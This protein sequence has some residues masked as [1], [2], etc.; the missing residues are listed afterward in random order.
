MV[1]LDNG[2]KITGHN[3]IIDCEKGFYNNLYT[4][5]KNTWLTTDASEYFTN[6][7]EFPCLS[8][9]NKDVL[10]TELTAEEIANA[11]EVL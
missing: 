11:V 10:D 2:E 9:E 6:V 4:T 1:N 7:Q 5:Q 3:A 8:D